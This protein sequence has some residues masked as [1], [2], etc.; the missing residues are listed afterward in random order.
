MFYSCHQITILELLNHS[1]KVY[2][3]LFTLISKSCCVTKA[4]QLARTGAAEIGAEGGA[5]DKKLRC[6]SQTKD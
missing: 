1:N 2:H 4:K 6:M 3:P 5:S